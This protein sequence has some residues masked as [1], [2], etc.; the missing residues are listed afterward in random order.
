VVDLLQLDSA[1]DLWGC[2]WEP[3]EQES[4]ETALVRA[5]NDSHPRRTRL[6]ALATC[7]VIA[8]QRLQAASDRV[9]SSQVFS[10]QEIAALDGETRFRRKL[11][12][13][14]TRMRGNV[15]GV[16]L[17]LMR[18]VTGENDLPAEQLLDHV[19]VRDLVAVARTTL[20]GRLYSEV[21][22]FIL[23]RG[24][25]QQGRVANLLHFRCRTGATSSHS[26]EIGA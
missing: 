7:Q 6:L 24:K 10:P 12:Q 1:L 25:Y 13:A 21:E 22:R 9:V 2:M 19:D 20:D 8:T 17:L 3:E 15:L 4:F 26:P 18:V 16:E 23:R 14:A 5:M 11:V